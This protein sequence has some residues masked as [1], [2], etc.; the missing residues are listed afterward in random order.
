MS[1]ENDI[2][3]RGSKKK[4]KKTPP[5]EEEIDED[6]IGIAELF[7]EQG[8]DDDDVN[9]GSDG[10]EED[11]NVDNS[12]DDDDEDDDDEDDDDEEDDDEDEDDDEEDDEEEEEEEDNSSIE[13]ND[14]PVE[15][16]RHMPIGGGHSS[17]AENDEQEVA[18]R[19]GKKNKGQRDGHN[20]GKFVPSDEPCGEPRE[21]PSKK[22]TKRSGP[23]GHSECFIS[24]EFIKKVGQMNNII[25][26]Q[27]TIE[28]DSSFLQISNIIELRVRQII[29]E[30]NK[31]YQKR[32]RYCIN[33]FLNLN[34][35]TNSCHYLNVTVPYKYQVS[36]HPDLYSQQEG[37]KNGGVRW[38]LVSKEGFKNVKNK[39]KKKKRKKSYL[40]KGRRRKR[41]NNFNLSAAKIFKEFQTQQSRRTNFYREFAHGQKGKEK[42]SPSGGPSG[43]TG[44]EDSVEVGI[45]GGN[46]GND[47]KAKVKCSST[48]M[49]ETLHSEVN[50]LLGVERENEKEDQEPRDAAKESCSLPDDPS[51]KDNPEIDVSIERDGGNPCENEE[52]ERNSV[53][54]VVQ[55]A[56]SHMALSMNDGQDEQKVLDGSDAQRACHDHSASDLLAEIER[57]LA[58]EEVHKGDSVKSIKE[59]PPEEEGLGNE[60]KHDEGNVVVEN[61]NIGDG[62]VGKDRMCLGEYTHREGSGKDSH[63][64]AM[65]T[66][67]GEEDN[68]LL[69][70]NLYLQKKKNKIKNIQNFLLSD[71]QNVLPVEANMT[72]FWLFIQNR[73]KK[74]KK[75]DKGKNGQSSSVV[76]DYYYGCG[77]EGNN[78]KRKSVPVHFDY[79]CYEMLYR[80]DRRGRNFHSYR[81]YA[82]GEK[83]VNRQGNR[84]LDHH[85]GNIFLLPKFYP[86][87][88]EY[89]ILSKYILEIIKDIINYRVNF[90][91]YNNILHIFTTSKEINKILANIFF[92]LFNEL[93]HNLAFNNMYASLMLLILVDGIIKNKNIDTHFYCVQI[94]KML[95]HVIIY[96]H[97]L[98]LKN[99]Y[100]ILLVKRKACDI[101]IDFCS[102]LRRESNNEIINIDYY[103]IYILS[104]L[105]THSK[106][107]YMHI[108]VSYYLI[109]LMP[110]NIHLKFFLAYTPNFLRIFFKKYFYHQNVYNKGKCQL[111]LSPEE[112]ELN[113]LF[114]FF[115]FHIYTLIQGS[116]YRI[117][118]NMDSI[119]VLDNAT[120][121]SYLSYLMDFIIQYADYHLP[122][123]LSIM[124]VLGRG[125]GALVTSAPRR[126]RGWK[127]LRKHSKG[128]HLRRK[129]QALRRRCS[130]RGKKSAKIRRK[131]IKKN[132]LKK[133]RKKKFKKKQL[134][135]DVSAV[136]AYEHQHDVQKLA[137]RRNYLKHVKKIYDYYAKQNQNAKDDNGDDL[138]D[139]GEL[140]STENM[141]ITGGNKKGFLTAYV[142]KRILLNKTLLQNMMQ[143]NQLHANIAVNKMLCKILSKFEKKR[144]KKVSRR[145]SREDGLLLYN[146]CYYF[147]YTL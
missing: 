88:K 107:T 134:L 114:N 73:C 11:D 118:K 89:A 126:K 30:A 46:Q 26:H 77:G 110:L 133:E 87:N 17:L 65:G 57:D 64:D 76:R 7:Q 95:I 60:Q 81:G 36:L 4:R 21:G 96:E 43:E 63:M 16:H 10:R 18:T 119:L 59:G 71:M 22:Q 35:F 83:L 24:K 104:K 131:K 146:S 145:R 48:D 105:L 5:R 14:V 54:G 111:S 50:D 41:R 3:K 115:F 84:H 56:S 9:D 147:L 100:L 109:Y 137:K 66:Q 106:C 143:T 68:N 58:S 8:E 38:R 93:E 15:R 102:V 132:R 33:R 117:F 29:E 139:R 129:S 80:V 42:R 78:E 62:D 127:R 20:D 40:N 136:R 75:G 112:T 103:L 90:F 91:D 67:S 34:D 125:S 85:H 49:D 27:T 70:Y 99:I 32:K 37:M 72:I 74:R 28:S 101:M 128:I 124:T 61:G 94:L 19:E 47:D 13:V 120:T 25:N 92:F 122:L 113:E 52:A 6:L 2:K 130:D 138:D 116:L 45:Y 44:G 97:D 141:N 23:Q 79:Q 31:F 123:L 82:K 51:S 1:F 108:Y 55:S 39:M 69:H 140:I 142:K 86:I 53:K 12:D 135:L 144:N 121:F 98:K